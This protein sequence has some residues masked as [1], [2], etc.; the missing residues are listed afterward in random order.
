VTSS[1]R[2]Q[3]PAEHRAAVE[4]AARTR[5]DDGKQALEALRTRELAEAEALSLARIRIQTDQMLAKQ[6]EALRDAEHKAEMVAIERRT[7][8]LDAAKEARRRQELEEQARHATEAKNVALQAAAVSAKEKVA[9]LEQLAQYQAE[10]RLALEA[11]KVAARTE[12]SLRWKARWLSLR[13]MAAWKLAAITLMVGL[14]TG[15]V[16]SS[17]HRD[18]SIA[19]ISAVADAIYTDSDRGLAPVLHLDRELQSAPR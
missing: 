1:S 12:S 11:M 7:A 15:Y 16:Y 13:L 5:L 17:H 3:T 10:Q 14:V 6:A 18:G 19:A 2:D 8:D 4:A 9:A